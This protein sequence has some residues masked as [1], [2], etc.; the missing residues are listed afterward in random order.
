MVR[1]ELGVNMTLG[2]SN[3]S[4]GLPERVKLNVAMLTM[5]LANGVNC[6]IVDPPSRSAPGDHGERCLAWPRRV[7]HELDHR[8]ARRESAAAVDGT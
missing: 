6:P 2:V 3:V 8:R 5:A 4:F 7:G 1:A